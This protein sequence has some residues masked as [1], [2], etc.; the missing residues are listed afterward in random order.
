[1]NRA[2][3]RAIGAFVLGALALSVV[4]IV[5]LGSGRLFAKQ[6]SFILFFP[7]DVSGLRIGASVRFRGVKV[8]T[9]T[10]IRLNFGDMME[11][12]MSNV[13][14]EKVRIPVIIEL[15]ET[16]IT[17]KG[18]HLNLDDPKVIQRLIARGL[19]GQ[20][21]VESYL[22][23]LAYVSLDLKPDTKPIFYLPR[24]SEYPEIPTIPTAFA[25]TQ[26]V[27]QTVL[28]KLS[29]ADLAKTLDKATAAMDAVNSLVTSPGLK[30]A[31]DGLDATEQNLRDTT[32]SLRRLTDNLNDK[33]V[34]LLESLRDTSHKAGELFT[35]SRES[36]DSVRATL[37]P[38][39][40]VI[41]RLNQSLDNVSSAA[42]AVHSL[43]NELE[44]NPSILVRGRYVPADGK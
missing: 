28:N 41:V 14:P 40:P 37:G 8:G 5:A 25:Q 39:S 43:A 16:Q 17:R 2:N 3:P 27:V 11:T 19:R 33:A 35:D 26:A 18:G 7:V 10:A 36:L 42:R 30:K 20:L 32:S 22:T 4:A 23:G 31:I 29:Q 13:S 34:P 12:Q 15:N 9:V 24:G 6:H 38:D 44:R 1:M 21:G